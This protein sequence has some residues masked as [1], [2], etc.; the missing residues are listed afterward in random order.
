MYQSLPQGWAK[1]E[2]SLKPPANILAATSRHFI[3]IESSL[4][5]DNEINMEQDSLCYPEAAANEAERMAEV[6][7]EWDSVSTV[8]SGAD[9]VKGRGMVSLS[10]PWPTQYHSLNSGHVFHH[11]KY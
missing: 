10:P 8:I 1:I 2:C 6:S 7:E 5:K 9:S 4:G 3:F 11:F